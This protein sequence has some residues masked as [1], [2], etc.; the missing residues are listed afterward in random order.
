MLDEPSL[1]LAPSLLK[2]V[3]DKIVQINQENKTTILIVKQKVREVFEICHK[4]YFLKLGKVDFEGKSDELKE[5]V[6]KL[7]EL[8][9]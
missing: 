2:S 7:K 3:F 1:G 5:N 9:L 6:N 8:F 4:V